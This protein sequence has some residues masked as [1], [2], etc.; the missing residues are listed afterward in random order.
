VKPKVALTQ[1]TSSSPLG[2]GPNGCDYQCGPLLMGERPSGL[3][4]QP[5]SIC[6]GPRRRLGV[7]RDPS[8]N[9]LLAVNAAVGARWHPRSRPPFGAVVGR[10]PRKIAAV[11]VDE[12]TPSLS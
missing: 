8:T 1:Q 11:A 3:R 10:V 12:A 2:L 6:L 7:R 4:V 9:R 5:A